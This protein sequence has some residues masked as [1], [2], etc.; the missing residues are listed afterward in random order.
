MIVISK[1]DVPNQLTKGKS[2]QVITRSETASIHK[3][4]IFFIMNDSGTKS[5]YLGE[6]FLSFQ[7]HRELNINKILEDDSNI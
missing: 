2:Y 1:I 5:W 6:L 7:E 4:Y 3:K